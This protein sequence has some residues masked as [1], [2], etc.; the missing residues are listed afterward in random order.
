[1]KTVFWAGFVDLLLKQQTAITSKPFCNVVKVKQVD[2]PNL[3]SWL[4]KKM[5]LK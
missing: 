3:Q 2:K 5:I 1:M 4:K